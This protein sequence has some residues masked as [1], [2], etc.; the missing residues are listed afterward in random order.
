MLL[1]PSRLL[2]SAAC[3]EIRFKKRSAVFGTSVTEPRLPLDLSSTHCSLFDFDPVNERTRTVHDNQS[4]PI[5]DTTQPKPQ[6]APTLCSHCALSA[7]PLLQSP[8]HDNIGNPPILVSPTLP[9]ILTRNA[10]RSS[11]NL[12]Y[13]PRQ[14]RPR[15][16]SSEGSVAATVW[17]DVCCSWD[18]GRSCAVFAGFGAFG[19]AFGFSRQYLRKYR[20]VL[21][22]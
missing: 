6:P 11:L 8:H 21:D 4:I 15:L 14:P 12:S 3:T 1:L 19:C 17:L 13:E 2:C 20:V 22:N 7:P 18:R 16:P 9:K 5:H 10:T